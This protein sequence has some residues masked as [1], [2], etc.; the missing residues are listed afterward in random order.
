M[1]AHPA[2]ERHVLRMHAQ[3]C[4]A[5]D[6]GMSELKA[7]LKK[8]QDAANQAA[9]DSVAAVKAAEFLGA[10]LEVVEAAVAATQAWE[11]SQKEMAALREHKTLDVRLGAVLAAKGMKVVDLVRSWDKSGDGAID[12]KEFVDNVLRLKIEAERGEIEELFDSLDEDHGGELST[13]EIKVALRTLQDRAEAAE[14]RIK[15]LQKD[16]LQVQL[17]AG[18]AQAE[19]RRVKEEDE[20][21]AQE[22][23]E[24][25]AAAA[26][27]MAAAA[28]EAKAAR[29]AAAAEKAAAAAA[30][31]AAFEAKIAAKRA[32]LGSGQKEK[33]SAAEG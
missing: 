5:G 6:L 24:A 17:R 23:A 10:R 3:P 1:H 13:D 11:A 8:L 4:T 14:A 32:A 25:E 28:A 30:K 2:H 29:E 12:K 33:R 16:S 18:E 9:A 21:A 27:Q 15:R 7:A 20:R 19:A 31:K 26:E 22:Q